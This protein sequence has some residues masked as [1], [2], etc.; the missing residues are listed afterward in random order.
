MVVGTPTKRPLH[1]VH[2]TFDERR[3]QRSAA[4]LHEDKFVP[5]NCIESQKRGPYNFHTWFD[6]MPISAKNPPIGPC[7]KL[8]PYGPE[9][10]VIILRYHNLLACI[11]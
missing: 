4:D 11:V 3:S 6:V 2:S 8:R 7:E 5:G 10:A 9:I 1:S